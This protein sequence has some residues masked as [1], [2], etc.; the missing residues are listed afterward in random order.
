MRLFYIFLILVIFCKTSFSQSKIEN[1]IPKKSPIISASINPIYQILVE[2]Y[3]K[4]N[5]R[6]IISPNIDQHD[7]QLKPSDMDNIINS[8]IVLFIDQNFEKNIAK[9]AKESL[10][11]KFFELSRIANLQILYNRNGSGFVDFHIWL[12]KDNS[13][14]IA[15]FIKE[16]ACLINENKC[17]FYQQNFLNFQIKANLYYRGNF[18]KIKDVKNRPYALYHDGYQYFEND[19]KTE[20]KIILADENGDIKISKLK[21][22]DKLAKNNGVKCIFNEKN[23]HKNSAAKLA[24]EYKLEYEI[25]DIIGDENDNFFETQNKIINNFINC[26]SNKIRF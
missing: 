16:K 20:S 24:K 14:K 1:N 18:L 3:G 17:N 10:Q 4:E 13:I 6:R 9:I 19:F 15:E 21:E 5:S 23:S 2:I 25:L 12:S 26:L 8:E 7:F 11:N 22:F